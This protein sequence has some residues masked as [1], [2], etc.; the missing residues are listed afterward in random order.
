M[1]IAILSGKGG[2]G[3]T[4]L[5][6]NLFSLLKNTTLIDTDIEEPNAHLFLDGIPTKLDTVY[7]HYPLVDETKCTRC[8]K[9][10]DHCNYNAII[11]TK[12]KVMVFP[13]LCHDCGLCKIV[14]PEDAI[15]Y[16]PKAIG[17]IY[18]LNTPS[19]PF[20][21]GLLNTG[22]IS[23]VKI[24]DALKD[25]TKDTSHLLIDCPPG[26]ACNT[27]TSIEGVDYAIVVSEPTPFGISDLTMVVELLRQRDIPFGVV[28]NKAGIGNL[29]IYE[30]LKEEKI[31]HLG[32][33]PFTEKRASLSASGVRLIDYDDDFKH[34][35][36][37][38]MKRVEQ[39]VH[40]A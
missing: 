6:V 34:R 8:G 15:S 21:Y 38:I 7:K 3:K 11:P 35:L 30:Y 5:S 31:V 9:C 33:I 17:D 14:C 40:Y 26:V 12:K 36:I 13:D 25:I 37:E 4:T 28:V 22:E 10:G 16:A 32:D 2:T 23:G 20:Y 19:K 27:S 29:D 39:E 1:K 18:E 24:I